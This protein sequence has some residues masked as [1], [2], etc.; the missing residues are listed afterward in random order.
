MLSSGTCSA[1]SFRRNPARTWQTA[2]ALLKDPSIRPVICRM[3][4]DTFS[5]RLYFVHRL[6]YD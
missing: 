5:M 6:Q 3:K 2:D 4:L 1:S